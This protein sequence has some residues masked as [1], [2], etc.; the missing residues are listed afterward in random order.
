MAT[1]E[2]NIKLSRRPIDVQRKKLGIKYA[3]T[4]QN[5]IESLAIFLSGANLKSK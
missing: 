1:N 2:K 3:P 4:N 5:L